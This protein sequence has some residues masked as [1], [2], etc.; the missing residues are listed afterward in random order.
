MEFIRNFVGIGPTGSEFRREVTDIDSMA[1]G[2][3]D[4]LPWKEKRGLKTAATGQP[5]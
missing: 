2:C 1:I 3:T 4:V 5:F